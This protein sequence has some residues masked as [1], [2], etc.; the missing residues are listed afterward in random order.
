MVKRFMSVG[1]RNNDTNDAK[2]RA[3]KMKQRLRQ[4]ITQHYKVRFDRYK[5]A[6]IVKISK[7]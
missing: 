1:K 7:E 6:T 5:D 2:E 3:E 4:K